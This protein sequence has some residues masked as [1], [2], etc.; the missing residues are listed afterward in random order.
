MLIRIELDKVKEPSP[1]VLKKLSAR[2]K[3]N[4]LELYELAE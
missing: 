1:E 3:I 2:Y 4:L